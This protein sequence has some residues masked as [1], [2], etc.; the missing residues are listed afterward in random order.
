MSATRIV[1]ADDHEMFRAGIRA[2]IAGQADMEV[3]GEASDGEEAV[4]LALELRP[5]VVLMDIGMKG[6]NGLE[7][8]RHVLGNTS[9][10]H[11]LALTA[12]DYAEYFFEIINAGAS[13]YVLKEASPSELFAAIRA[14]AEGQAYLYPSMTRKLLND[15]MRRVSAGEERDS[16]DGLSPRE[17]EVL[18]LV[19]EG[20]SNRE[21][22]EKLVISV[23]T[24]EVHRAR[25]MQKL[26]MHN[27]AQLV[28]YAIR[29]GLIDV[30][31]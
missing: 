12:H 20:H 25:L 9:D 16:Y 5:D 14:A 23:N 26:D 31:L 21:I 24:V 29:S 22:A 18:K 17:R 19:A 8:T 11:V 6:M 27:R 1:L 3:V 2:L 7:A 28:K 10:V 13:G 15:Y 4:R 30:G